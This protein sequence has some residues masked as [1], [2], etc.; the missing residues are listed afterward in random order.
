M[1]EFEKFLTT[2]YSKDLEE[3]KTWYSSV[4]E[5]YN[6]TRPRYPQKILDRVLELAQ[7]PQNGSILE[8]GCGPGTATVDLAEKGFKMVCLEP[9]LEACQIA[10]QNC[11]NYP[12]VEVKN[13]TFEEWELDTEKFD[14]VVAA[15]SFHWVKPEVGCSKAAAILKDN[16]SLI[17]LWNTPPQP[18]YETYQVLE[19][20]YEKKAPSM[21]DYRGYEDFNF[22][23][24]NLK[25]MG[26]K[27]IESGL[28][29]NLVFDLIE[30]EVTYRIDDYIGLLSTLSP[31][32]MI[33]SK[34]RNDLFE[35]L[36]EKLFDLCGKNIQLF[37]LSAFQITQK[38]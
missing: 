2:I 25:Q 38:A 4:A 16:G 8:I 29:K 17:L 20:I 31:Y 11:Q 14:A 36:R 30:C 24:K 9:S 18:S 6:K 37:Y 1:A 7:I 12:H 19:E 32:I 33:D 23:Q 10:R 35:S 27:V 34:Q 15:T 22:H 26:K 13:S 28:F 21:T 5:A 3:K